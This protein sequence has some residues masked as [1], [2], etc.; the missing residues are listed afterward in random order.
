MKSLKTPLRYPGGKSR[1]VVKLFQYLPDMSN[2]TEFRE[3]FLGGGSMSIAISKQYPDIPVWV[4]DLYNPLYTFWCVL[5]DQPQDLYDALKGYKE[6]LGPVPDKKANEQE[7]EEIEEEE[8]VENKE[9]EEYYDKGRE[10]FNQ[11]KIGI[12][13]PEADDLYRATAFY[14]LNKCSF[15]GL[16]ENSSFSPQASI[17]NFSMNNIDKIPGYG[18]IV[19]DWKITNLSYEKLLTDDRSVF[20]Y[21]DP[22]Y[23][24]KD[25]LYGRKGSMHKGFD[26][27]KFAI[28]CDRHIC[29]Q[30]VSYNSSNLVKNRF[31]G[32]RSV[33][34]AHTYT[35]R[36]DKKYTSGQ[37]S[38]H[39]LVLINYNSDGLEDT[40]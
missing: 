27:D 24:I 15:S 22:P 10:L 34:F 30:L 31:D 39:E 38:R 36:S 9:F 28:D 4:N 19:K 3:P 12:N 13:H 37:E 26:H 25:N 40:P 16:T 18:E 35:M 5:R 33:D 1:A 32:W 21:L 14:I 23:D 8:E 29:P 20:V 17:S 6:D 11:M 7:P 2:I